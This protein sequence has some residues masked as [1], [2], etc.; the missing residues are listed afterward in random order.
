[1]QKTV[2]SDLGM[3][4]ISRYWFLLDARGAMALIHFFVYSANTPPEKNLT[5]FSLNL[6]AKSAGKIITKKFLII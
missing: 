2:N 3:S 4:L 6:S 1:M 5:T